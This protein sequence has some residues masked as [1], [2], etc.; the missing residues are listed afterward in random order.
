[1]VGAIKSCG[2]RAAS[3][4]S[5]PV[6]G[7]KLPVSCNICREDGCEFP[8]FRHCSPFTTR[9]SNTINRSGL[10]RRLGNARSAAR[11]GGFYYGVVG[12]G[13]YSWDNKTGPGDQSVF[14]CAGVLSTGIYVTDVAGTSLS[15]GQS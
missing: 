12:A 3:Q 10:V 9:R 14:E 13:G 6:G 15:N 2:A 11:S 5:A 8:G 7:G 4:A 1:M